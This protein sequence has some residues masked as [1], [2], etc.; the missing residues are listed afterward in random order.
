VDSELAALSSAA[1]TT[2]VALMTTD[3][4]EQVKAT[5]LGLWRRSYPR[6]ADVVDADLT[7]ARSEALAARQAG[8]EVAKAALVS[9]WRSRL[10]RLVAADALIQAEL[11]RLMNQLQP[12]LSD[13]GP[14]GGVVMTATASGASRIN[15]AGRDQTVFGG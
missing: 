11:K 4:W 7:A 3:S 14:A 2:L 12:M 13:V 15:Q 8:D 5:F 10:G 9:E 6:Q 1:A